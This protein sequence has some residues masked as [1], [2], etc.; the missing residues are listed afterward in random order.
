MMRS[1]IREFGRRRDKD[2][3]TLRCLMPGLRKDKDYQ[4]DESI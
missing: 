2:A 1:P 3:N 4:E